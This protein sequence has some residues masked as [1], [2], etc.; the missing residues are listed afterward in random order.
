MLL[1]GFL[2]QNT[3]LVGTA[4]VRTPHWYYINMDTHRKK[5]KRL[6]V[7]LLKGG[8]RPI[9]ITRISAVTPKHILN[10]AW[11][12]PGVG[13]EVERAVTL[14]HL[15]AI[16]RAWEDNQLRA[17]H[18]LPMVSAMIV[19]DDISMELVALWKNANPSRRNITLHDVLQ[20]LEVGHVGWELVQLAT[21]C[22]FKGECE[23]YIGEM[24]TALKKSIIVLPRESRWRHAHLWSA[25]AYAV[26]PK[27]QRM[28]LDRLW[29][30]GSE[31][32]AFNAL[33]KGTKFR[34]D[35][36]DT[37][38]IVADSVLF[39]ATRKNATFFSARP[40]FCSRTEHSHLHENHLMPQ[41][42]SKYLME[43]VL[44]L[45]SI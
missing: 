18:G 9:D 10:G 3:S 37:R 38:S 33:P 35:E 29:P 43:S 28:I 12:V 16:K 25:V 26:S 8:V 30:G 31:G 1:D 15:R 27:G 36:L 7:L 42:R 17:K 34:M 24:G 32:P 6:E 44:Y 21:M 45:G 19:E 41:E 13:R 4:E 40:L 39:Q 11:T 22:F 23:T 20:A 14:S 2:P 5:G